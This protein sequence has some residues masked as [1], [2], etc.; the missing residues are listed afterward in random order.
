MVNLGTPSGPTSAS[1]LMR[2]DGSAVKKTLI[3]RED[4]KPA[5]QFVSDLFVIV[6]MWV[7]DKVLLLL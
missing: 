2:G 4:G 3:V 6:S 7:T 5:T 1:D